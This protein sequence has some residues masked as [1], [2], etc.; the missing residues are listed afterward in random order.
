M[1]SIS[2]PR[3][4]GTTAPVDSPETSTPGAQ[5]RGATVINN[6]V[7]EKIAGLAV[8]Q[9]PGVH[10]LGGSAARALGAIR[11]ALSSTDHSQGVSVQVS[12]GEVSVQLSGRCRRGARSHHRRH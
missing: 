12:E 7:V 1:T 4:T 10:A 2:P 6:S 8:R 3:P 9:V 5:V 11:E